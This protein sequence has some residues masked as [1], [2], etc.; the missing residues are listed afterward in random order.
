MKKKQTHPFDALLKSANRW[1]SKNEN[2][3]DRALGLPVWGTVS[4]QNYE[5]LT[6]EWRQTW[7]RRH[8]DYSM[9]EVKGRCVKRHQNVIVYSYW[10][11]TPVQYVRRP[12]HGSKGFMYSFS[13]HAATYV[14]RMGRG[15]K[16]SCCHWHADWSTGLKNATKRSVSISS[17]KE[18]R[19]KTRRIV[20]YRAVH[21]SLHHHRRQMIPH[22]AW[23]AR[24]RFSTR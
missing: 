18:K 5:I 17:Q 9:R 6:I 23:N 24:I 10:L 13:Q 16:S 20:T 2:T 22:S 14:A 8:A 21:C 1:H 12:K 4:L 3:E 11:T 15:N 19:R 7:T